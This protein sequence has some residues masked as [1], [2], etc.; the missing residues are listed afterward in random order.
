VSEKPPVNPYEAFKSD[1]GGSYET[2][3]GVDPVRQVADVMSSG[4]SI[5]PGLPLQGM[6]GPDGE[7]DFSTPIPGWRA[8]KSKAMGVPSIQSFMPGPTLFKG[9]VSAER[10]DYADEVN[11]FLNL[12]GT[13]KAYRALD[14]GGGPNFRSHRPSDLIAGDMGFRTPEGSTIFA[15]RGGVAGIKVSDLCQ[16]LFSQADDLARMVS[17]NFDLFSDW[18]EMRFV[19]EGG[20]TRLHVKGNAKGTKTWAG[21]HDVEIIIGKDPVTDDF[22]TLKLLDKESKE[23]VYT[24]GIDQNGDQHIYLRRDQ[25]SQIM[26][27]KGEGIV[28]NVRTVVG[29]D[30]TRDVDGTFVQN[31]NKNYMGGVTTS[32]MAPMGEQLYAYLKSVEFFMNTQLTVNAQPFGGPTIPGCGMIFPFPPVPDFLSRVFLNVQFPQHDPTGGDIPGP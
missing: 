30:E 11:T 23:P 12:T 8:Q 9:G 3:L 18:G 17:R 19:N 28:G 13:A 21:V 25:V 14:H 2:V 20:A 1:Q 4:D 32:E 29:G 26:G 27:N 24:V 31:C 22:I 5:Q 10:D 6:V 16:L 15:G 7:G